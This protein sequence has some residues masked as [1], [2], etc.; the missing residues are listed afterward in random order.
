M[1]RKRTTPDPIYPF[2]TI[3]SDCNNVEGSYRT[4][5]DAVQNANDCHDKE[6][7]D[8]YIYIVEVKAVYRIETEPHVVPGSLED[9]AAF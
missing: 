2:L 4:L 1:S 5:E 3:N 9:L 6:D 8:S 7:L